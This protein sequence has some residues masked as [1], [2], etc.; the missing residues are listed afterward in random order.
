MVAEQENSRKTIDAGLS[1]TTQPT[2]AG[3][4]GPHPER[5]CRPYGATMKHRATNV[6]TARAISAYTNQRYGPS[7][8]PGV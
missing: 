7:G 6:T 4:V 2:R 8:M 3:T 5:P 1:I